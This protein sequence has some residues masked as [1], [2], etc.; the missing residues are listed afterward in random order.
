MGRVP[1]VRYHASTM[2]TRL[3]LLATTL[4]LP[5][6]AFAFDYTSHTAY[7]DVR[8]TSP[9]AAAI[10]MLTN[11]GVL[12]GY[13]GNFFGPTRGINRAEFLKIALRSAPASAVP[14]LATAPGADCFPDVHA[15]QWFASVVCYAKDHGIVGGFADASVSSDQWLFHPDSPVLYGEALKMLTQIYGYEVHAVSGGRDWAE[16]FYDSAKALN[17]DLPI[18][19]SLGSPLTR[20]QSARLVGAFVAQSQGKLDEFHLAESGTLPEASS[21]SSVSSSASSSSIPSSSSSASSA[22]SSSISSS[23][24]SVASLFTLPP[25]N[26]FLVVGANSDAIADGTFTPTEPSHIRNARIKIYNETTAINTLDLVTSKGDLV[27]SLTRRITT[28]QPDYKTIYEASLAPDQDFALAANVPFHVIARANVRTLTN[29]GSSEQ[30]LDIRSFEITTHGDVSGDTVTRVFPIPFPKQQTSF[31]RIVGVANAGQQT[32]ALTAGTNQVLAAFA[33]SGSVI[34]TKQLAINQL[35]FTVL[36]Q[37]RSAVTHWHL[38]SKGG[39]LTVDCSTGSDGISCPLIPAT[40]GQLPTHQ[41]LTLELRG[42]VTLD[43]NPVNAALQVSLDQAG[44]P[45]QPGSV[46]WTDGSGMFRWIEGPSP[47]AVGT[48]WK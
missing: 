38:T 47:V 42:D 39:G 8:A 24:S 12:Q 23:A 27:L 6:A 9:D 31:G 28:D 10:T 5:V 7:R 35:V 30:L 33:F 48:L 37:N 34:D 2:H 32:G 21:S 20:G 14:S 15:D 22:V 46:Y 40:M 16:P 13:A 43:P 29:N 25:V 36:Q 3:T 45:S 1:P 17:V 44:S 11:A 18:T 19:I 4:L 26:H 41:P